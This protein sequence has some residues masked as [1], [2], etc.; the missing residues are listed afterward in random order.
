[1]ESM[2]YPPAGNLEIALDVGTTGRGPKRN[3]EKDQQWETVWALL[4]ERKGKH[5]EQVK[6]EDVEELVHLSLRGALAWPVP[7]HGPRLLPPPNSNWTRRNVPSVRARSSFSPTVA[8]FLSVCLFAC[9]PGSF[10]PPLATFSTREQREFHFLLVRVPSPVLRIAVL[11]V[12]SM[13]S[14]KKKNA[15]E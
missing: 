15:T 12:V 6:E 5:D 14:K 8:F 3:G 13:I 4:V 9:S 11:P 1:M 10:G 2:E 7:K